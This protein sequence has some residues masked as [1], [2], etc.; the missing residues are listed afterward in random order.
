MHLEICRESS[1][2]YD[3][4][5]GTSSNTYQINFTIYYLIKLINIVSIW[6]EISDNS[7]SD[8]WQR[9]QLEGIK[10]IRYDFR[11]GWRDVRNIPQIISHLGQTALHST[12]LARVLNTNISYNYCTK[13]QFFQ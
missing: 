11:S 7:Y 10:H 8:K 1:R 12:W 3:N 4:L 2:I 6:I 9:V 13:L 5:Y